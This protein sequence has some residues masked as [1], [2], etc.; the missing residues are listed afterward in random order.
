[1]IRFIS[2]V[3]TDNTDD[4]NQM[5]SFLLREDGRYISNYNHNYKTS[6]SNAVIK[7]LNKKLSSYNSSFYN[8][9]KGIHYYSFISND[10]NNSSSNDI[11]LKLEVYN[12]SE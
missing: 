4:E 10:E 1:M 2:R 12:E 9:P 6:K 5:H 8:I 3:V 11:Y 7:D